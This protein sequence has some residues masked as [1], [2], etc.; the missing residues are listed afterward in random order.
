MILSSDAPSDLLCEEGITYDDVVVCL[1]IFSQRL[2][3]AGLLHVVR[4]NVFELKLVAE[5]VSSF[6]DRPDP[7]FVQRSG[8]DRRYPKLLNLVRFFNAAS[9]PE[10]HC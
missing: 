3:E 2:L 4:I 8:E 5:A 1:R 6:V 7:G 10:A 9:S